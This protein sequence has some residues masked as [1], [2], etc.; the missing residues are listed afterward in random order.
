MATV[1]PVRFGP[2]RD[3]D[4]I[5]AIARL[6]NLA[7]TS[8][9]DQIEPTFLRVVGMDQVR[10]ARAES[11]PADAPPEACLARL[12]MGQYFGGKSVPMLGIAAVAV[13][14][15]ARGKGLGLSLM[16]ETVREM[17]REGVAL[18]CLYPSTQ[19]LYRQVGY[20]QAGHRFRYELDL[21]RLGVTERA[22]TVRP[23][24]DADEPA[25]RACQRRFAA[26]NDGM[27][28]RCELLWKRTRSWRGST[29][30][31]WIFAQSDTAEPEGLVLLRQT[32]D[33]ASFRI[34]LSL[35]DLAFTTARAGRRVLG[36]LADF[37]SMARGVE[38]FAGPVHPI[39]HLMPQ[40]VFKSEFKF[41][42]MLRLI[43][44]PAAMTARGWPAGTRAEVS[45][46]INDDLLPENHGVWRLRIADGH[47]SLERTD[48]APECEL[49]I[50]ALACFYAGFLSVPQA[51]LVG[52]VG[53]SDKAL[54]QL[55][56]AFPPGCA[57]MN[58]MF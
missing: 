47:A 53:G 40:Q 57:G 39:V 22:L 8:P 14:P 24:T 37:G 28:D 13:A 12:P 32:M 23:L 58:D 51:R 11:A 21:A 44:A 10:V 15:E 54:A 27:L 16:R 41:H 4:D 25:V 26:M 42:W 1:L 35:T 56:S 5:P 33:A 20:E 17:R 43:D 55:A 36:F 38:F 18:S 34:D 49:D 30:T 45:L 7:F 29:S 3:P 52:I 46:Q 48:T 2:P 50:R 19:A 9:T 6:L 31:G